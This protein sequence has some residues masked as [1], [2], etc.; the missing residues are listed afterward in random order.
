MPKEYTFKDELMALNHYEVNRNLSDTARTLKIGRTTLHRWKTSGVP[1]SITGGLDWDQYI[2]QKDRAVVKKATEETAVRVNRDAINFI[3]ESKLDLGEIIEKLK[4]DLLAGYAK[5]TFG[6]YEKL[7]M[8]YLRLDNQANDR[9]LWQRAFIRDVIRAVIKRYGK[10]SELDLLKLD[11]ATAVE[12]SFKNLAVAN[13][14]ELPAPE[15]QIPTNQELEY[16]DAVYA[17]ET[18][19][20]VVEPTEEE[21]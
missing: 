15:D 5:P 19:A 17:E 3:E 21:A 20:E 1:Q 4:T 16:E 10:T 7:L 18:S 9:V 12:T 11:I 8:M 6:D 13:P 14:Q 2:E